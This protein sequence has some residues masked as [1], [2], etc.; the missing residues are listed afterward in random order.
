VQTR[1]FV[2]PSQPQTLYI[3]TF[4]LY[5]NAVFGLLF[6][7]SPLFFFGVVPGL[8]LT[9]GMAA[10]AY[11][12]ANEKRWGYWLGVGIAGLALVPFALYIVGNGLG[13]LFQ[14]GLLISL[15]FPVALFVLLVHPMSR[16][17]Q[18]VWFS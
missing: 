5:F 13:S 7:S 12:I 14:I 15:V 4:L 17:Y 11:G 8:A 2:N 1:R 3:A 9:V 18:R 10:G 6:A 16:Q